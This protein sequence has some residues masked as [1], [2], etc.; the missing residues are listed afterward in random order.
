[1]EVTQLPYN[2]FLGLET[3][4]GGRL[5]LPDD[6]RYTNHL[7]TVH[8]GALFSLAE[9]SSGQFLLRSVYLDPKAV[10]VVLRSAEIK[11]RRPARG[12]ILSRCRCTLDELETLQKSL[13][14]RGRATV[15]V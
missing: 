15:T 5:T 7:G 8:A 14:S 11:Y 12:R 6:S 9:A 2:K 10:V 3:H 1:M 13:A 4:E